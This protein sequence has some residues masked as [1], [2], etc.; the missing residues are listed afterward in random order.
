MKRYASDLRDQLGQGNPE[1]LLRGKAFCEDVAVHGAVNVTDVLGRIEFGGAHNGFT[2][3]WERISASARF[4]GGIGWAAT[5]PLGLQVPGLGGWT[6]VRLSQPFPGTT[7]RKSIDMAYMPS[8][9]RFSDWYVAAGLDYGR[10]ISDSEVEEGQRFSVEGGVKFRFP[11]PD[12]G[13]FLGGRVGIRANG[14]QL[15]RQRL[16]FEIGAGIW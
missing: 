16:V 8:A 1:Q 9:S 15:D 6:V 11:L 7:S 2:R 14:K 3:W 12:L 10:F 4:D 5:V 13:T